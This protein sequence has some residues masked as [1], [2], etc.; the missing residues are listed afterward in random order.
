MYA[1]AIVGIP[2]KRPPDHP[3][4]VL[5]FVDRVQQPIKELAPED[6]T[7][8]FGSIL[9]LS[10]APIHRRGTR[11]IP[12]LGRSSP[13]LHDPL[14]DPLASQ[15]DHPGPSSAFGGPRGTRAVLAQPR[16]T[17]RQSARLLPAHWQARPP[18]AQ[19][20][21]PAARQRPARS[22]PREGTT[23]RTTTLLS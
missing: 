2:D 3:P 23:L 17:P 4:D 5:S 19:A 1:A 16:R 21:S 14:A 10:H 6:G 7:N 12:P 18:W 9:M 15:Q 11:N 13:R 22:R 8:D 20:R